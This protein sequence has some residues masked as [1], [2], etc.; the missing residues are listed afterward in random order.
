MCLTLKTL[1]IAQITRVDRENVLQTTFAELESIEDFCMTFEVDFIG[2][3]AKDYGGSRKE[4]IRLVNSAMKEKYFDNGLREFLADDYYYIRVMM[5]IALL[6]N[7]QLPTILPL[8]IIDSLIQP[9]TS[10][11]VANL[12]K[13]LNK[14]ELIRI[15]QTI[16]RLLHLL[17]PSNTCLT[18]R[19]LIQ[20][21]NPVFAPEGP[22]AHSK[23]KEVY[24]LFVKY[25][26]QVASGRQPSVTLSSI[27]IF[28]TGAAEEPV[29]G[30]TKQPTIT[31]VNG[32]ANDQVN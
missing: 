25:I 29:L 23:E 9:S 14:F 13:G 7:G 2:D 1:R 24:G 17:R 19:I 26:R 28:V 11:C 16:P 8:D 4:W 5:G 12:Q 30:F 15:F 27:L 31:F 20:L 3:V 21:F 6:Q 32:H 10:I 18:A 22:T